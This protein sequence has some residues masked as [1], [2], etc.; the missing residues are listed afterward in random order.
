MAFAG[1]IEEIIL[2]DMPAA[3][4]AIAYDVHTRPVSNDLG[5]G[6]NHSTD[7][8]F[9]FFPRLLLPPVRCY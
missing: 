6:W 5:L 8:G 9:Y 2:N 3:C 4:W 1:N 7:R